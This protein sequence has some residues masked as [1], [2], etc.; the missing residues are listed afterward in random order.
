MFTKHD[1]Y[2]I[3]L[4]PTKGRAYAMDRGYNVITAPWQEVT[5]G[6]I[7]EVHK[8]F[9]PSYQH[10]AWARELDDDG[11]LHVACWTNFYEGR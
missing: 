6:D 1:I 8:E 7:I 11:H 10:P 3:I 5:M 2:C 4:Y 9:Q